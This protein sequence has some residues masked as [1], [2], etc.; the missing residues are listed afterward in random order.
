MT[1]DDFLKPLRECRSVR[2]FAMRTWRV[3]DHGGLEVT[4]LLRGMRL[5]V[6]AARPGSL[7]IED[8]TGPGDMEPP[9]LP[10]ERVLSPDE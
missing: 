1:P 3:R 10:G 8:V 6:K 7:R 2:F 5:E 9:Y 4:P